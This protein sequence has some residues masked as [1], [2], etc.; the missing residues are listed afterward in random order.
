MTS[1]KLACIFRALKHQKVWFGGRISSVVVHML[2]SLYRRLVYSERLAQTS[3][4][5]L[6]YLKLA[7]IFRAAYTKVL[8]WG[9]T[10]SVA[11]HRLSGLYCMARVFRALTATRVH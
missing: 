10:S 11:V 6:L 1:P 3:V 5:T 4:D 8:G 2:S 9:R 7:R